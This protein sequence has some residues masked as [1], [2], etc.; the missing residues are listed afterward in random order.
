MICGFN[1]QQ[2]AGAMFSLPELAPTGQ[3]AVAKFVT[4]D[5]TR[6]A[7]VVAFLWV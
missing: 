5:R 1:G 7:M 4:D 3:S 2:G 6:L